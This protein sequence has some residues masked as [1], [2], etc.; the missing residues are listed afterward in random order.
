M[1]IEERCLQT[2]EQLE[3]RQNRVDFEKAGLKAPSSTWTYMINDNP[4]DG[5]LSLQIAGNI[6]MALGA[7]LWWPLL[8]L[9][10][11]WKKLKTGKKRGLPECEIM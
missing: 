11:W 4:F 1:E 6:G 10:S 7:G 8:F 2:F 3:V 9:V 5:I